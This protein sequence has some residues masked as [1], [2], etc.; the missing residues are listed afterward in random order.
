MIGLGMA[1]SSSSFIYPLQL[2]LE[3]AEFDSFDVR[4]RARTLSD[5]AVVVVGRIE[6]R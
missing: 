5:D 3:K 2:L 6:L 1:F 4:A